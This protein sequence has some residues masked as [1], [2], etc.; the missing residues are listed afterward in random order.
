MKILFYTTYNNCNTNFTGR[1]P[2]VTKEE[3]M[4]LI[5]KG[6]NSA[7]IGRFYGKAQSWA[8]ITMKKYGLQSKHAETVK[9][10]KTCI[11]ELIANGTS[12]KKIANQFN[13]S[14]RCVYDTAVNILGREKLK[15]LKIQGKQ[16]K[17]EQ[18]A[19]KLKNRIVNNLDTD[20]IYENTDGCK[21]KLKNAETKIKREIRKEN[22]FSIAN[23]ILDLVKE[24]KKF[25]EA[26]KEVGINGR[27]ILSYTDK[28]SL[29]EAR[30][31]GQKYKLSVIKDY[32]RKGFTVR[33][34]AKELGCSEETIYIRMG[35]KY[36][37]EWK[38]EQIKVR[39]KDILEYR[40]Q[41]MSDKQISE[42]LNISESTVKRT[43]K[44]LNN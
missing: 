20:D 28:K 25:K 1:K 5:D 11:T 18:K 10:L 31:E 6:Y 35:S 13:L 2:S 7:D 38:K 36:R 32:I 22:M 27:T 16:N 37:S 33:Q 9:K 30:I 12:M 24:G 26:A 29:E 14:Q 39:I 41:G 40:L 43:I 19:E 17:V 21:T 23:Q 4:Q 3:L 8:F 15:E 34:I 42:K 44:N